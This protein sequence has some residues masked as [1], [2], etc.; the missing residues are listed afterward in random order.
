MDSHRPGMPSL[1]LVG[2]L[3][4]LFFKKR[5]MFNLFKNQ[6][7]MGGQVRVKMMIVAK[8]KEP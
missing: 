5:T 3:C 7:K 6:Q 1:C 8:T 2:S 4:S